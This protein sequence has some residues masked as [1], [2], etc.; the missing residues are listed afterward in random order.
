M[1]V[2]ALTLVTCLA[3]LEVGLR[4]IGRYPLNSINGYHAEE[5]LSYGL[6][7]NVTSRVFWPTTSYLVQT[8][9]FG[10]RA[11]GTGP[12]DLTSKPYYAVLGSSDAFGNGLDYEKTFVGVFAG[13]M[14]GHQ[15]EVVN[16]AVG[17]HHLL[18]QMAR[19]ENFIARVPAPPKAV[20][21]ILNPLFIA[22]FDDTHPNIVVRSGEL[23]NEDNWRLPL[24][25]MILSKASNAYC[26]F[27]DG[28][29]NV[30][31]RYFSRADFPLDFYVQ[32]YSNSMAFRTPHVIA[33]FESR[34]T[35]LEAF[36]RRQGA[37]PICVYS[38]TTGGF[39][40]DKLRDQGKLDGSAFD[41]QFFRE[42][43]RRHCASA[44]IQF[45][46]F[47]PM[48]QERYNRGE[49]LNFDLDAHFNEPTSQAVGEY[50]Y[51]SLKP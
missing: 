10:F 49:K 4:L 23:F 41:T 50:L 32:R 48:L 6:K 22:G 35:D 19:F 11:A 27:R 33:E 42:L 18:E 28:I 45:V 38:P 36:V 2:V 25:K 15:T 26:F 16:L 29:R 12:R 34:M 21:I 43:S 7:K 9:D 13:K 3:M 47:E 44:G 46:D 37:T 30:Q 8:D 31:L 24:A 39:L 5:G 51:M 17:G 14:A 1:G 40:L 20:L